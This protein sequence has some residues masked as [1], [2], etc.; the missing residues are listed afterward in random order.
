MRY[1]NILTL[2]LILSSVTSAQEHELEYEGALKT[3]STWGHEY[4]EFPIRFAQEINYE[5][6]EDAAF[7]RGWSDVESEEFWSYV[8]AWDIKLDRA[9]TAGELE[10]DLLLYFDG[11]NGLGPKSTASPDIQ[12]SS[13]S[14]SKISNHKAPWQ[15][16]GKVRT[17]DR[18]RTKK[19]ITLL[20]KVEQHIC[21]NTGQSM[22][23]FRFSP[24]AFE[25]AIWKKLETV[26]IKDGFCPL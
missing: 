7:P 18:F 26:V 19:P 13:A 11:L 5:G 20:V 1:L 23:I 16:K 8:F 12:Q 9:V 2:I 15:F 3:D 21:K 17:Y 24:K 10:R 22:I 4:F 25:E 14:I 6:M